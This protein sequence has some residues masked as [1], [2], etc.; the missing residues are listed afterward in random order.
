MAAPDCGHHHGDPRVAVD[1]GRK[2]YGVGR[3]RVIAKPSTIFVAVPKKRP[4]PYRRRAPR[5]I[6]Q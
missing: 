5:G 2:T 1:C 4:G 3:F 6:S